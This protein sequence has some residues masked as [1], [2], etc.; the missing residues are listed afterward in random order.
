MLRF[1]S[2]S[3]FSL[4]ISIY[5]YKAELSFS[6]VEKRNSVS[7]SCAGMTKTNQAELF[8]SL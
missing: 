3:D 7:K 1:I 5:S 4:H 6:A 2:G 8:S